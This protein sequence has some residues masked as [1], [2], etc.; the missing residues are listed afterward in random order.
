MKPLAQEL[1]TEAGLD[2]IEIIILHAYL[3][4]SCHAR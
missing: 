3:G 4:F 1:G 2:R